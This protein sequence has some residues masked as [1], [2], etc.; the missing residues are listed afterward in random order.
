MKLLSLNLSVLSN[1]YC[2]A[3]LL[4]PPI[5]IPKNTLACIFEEKF[6]TL[7]YEN[8]QIIEFNV[9]EI[10]HGWRAIKIDTVLNFNDSGILN[11]ILEPLCIAKISVLVISSFN[12]DYILIKQNDL[13]DAINALKNRNHFINYN[14]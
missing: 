4:H 7:I 1:T 5:E 9:I 8:N 2:I 14:Y 12:T 3:K 10:S 13:I 6:I 11:S